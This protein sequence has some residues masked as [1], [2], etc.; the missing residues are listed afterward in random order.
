MTKDEL[1]ALLDDHEV[2]AKV[3][4]IVEPVRLNA[5]SVEAPTPAPAVPGPGWLREMVSRLPKR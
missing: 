4:A 2:R 5:A 3:L 1:L